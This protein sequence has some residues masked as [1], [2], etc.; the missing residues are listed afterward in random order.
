[1]VASSP[2]VETLESLPLNNLPATVIRIFWRGK[3]GA[4]AIVLYSWALPVCWLL[5]VSSLTDCCTHCSGSLDEGT[6]NSHPLYG[7]GMCKWPGCETVFGDFQA[8][9]KWVVELW[10]PLKL[11]WCSFTS[12]LMCSGTDILRHLCIYFRSFEWPICNKSLLAAFI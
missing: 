8:F 10:I 6:Q 4:L 7:N 2:L 12:I 1:M 9:N 5:D 11:A 3:R